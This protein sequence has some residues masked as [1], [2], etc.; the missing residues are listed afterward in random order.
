[1]TYNDWIGTLGVGIILLAYFFNTIKMIPENG[2]LFF[3][4]NTLGGAL[5]CY[6]AVLIDFIPFVV[7]EAIWT[8]VS[9]YGLFS[10]R[11][12]TAA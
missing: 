2:R 8:V 4:L 1:M 11:D 10:R 3:V 12:A 7:L 9:V 5:S 6:A